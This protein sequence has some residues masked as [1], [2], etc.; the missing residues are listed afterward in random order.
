[1]KQLKVYS[2]PIRLPPKATGGS[3]LTCLPFKKTQKKPGTWQ[4]LWAS[5][6]QVGGR[7]S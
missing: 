5:P 4:Q 3:R 7:R 6:S 2:M 1:V